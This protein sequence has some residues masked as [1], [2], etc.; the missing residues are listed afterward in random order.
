MIPIFIVR[1]TMSICYTQ[2]L[3]IKIAF[4]FPKAPVMHAFPRM[5]INH[6]SELLLRK[7]KR[8][9]T[10]SLTLCSLARMMDLK[11]LSKLQR[12]K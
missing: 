6:F 1:N 5:K 11:L 7:L 4:L 3:K 2:K 10:V 9:I 12:N 8:E